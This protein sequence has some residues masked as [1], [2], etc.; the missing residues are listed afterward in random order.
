MSLFDYNASKK[1]ALAD[2]P[3][4]ALIM[5]AMRQDE[6]AFRETWDELCACNTPGGFLPGEP[7]PEEFQ[8][9]LDQVRAF[10]LV[11]D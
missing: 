9:A 2:Y 1:I 5:A 3:F 11:E 4:Y 8:E 6:R 10:T 7:V